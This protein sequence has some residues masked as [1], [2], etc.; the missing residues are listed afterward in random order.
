MTPTAT[1]WAVPGPKRSARLALPGWHRLAGHSSCAEGEEQT[2]T[3]EARVSIR[4]GPSTL[5][6]TMPRRTGC[7]VEAEIAARDAANTANR[8]KTAAFPVA[9]SL[10]RFDVGG[11][12]VTQATFD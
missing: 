3:L 1:T 5:P 6:G 11:S 7:L 8:L 10:E 2:H 4:W 12:S 9:K